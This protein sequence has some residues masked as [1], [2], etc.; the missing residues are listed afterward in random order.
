MEKRLGETQGES[1][2]AHWKAV[3]IMQAG[4][5]RGSG[6]RGPGGGGEILVIVFRLS[7]QDLLV[8]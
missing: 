2:E 5:Y 4:D 8:D 1:R 7:P 6:Q 3:A